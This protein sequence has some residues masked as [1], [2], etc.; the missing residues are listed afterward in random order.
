M[1]KHGLPGVA[2]AFVE[3]GEIAYTQ[4]YGK[5][6]NNQPMT[7][8][9]PMFIGSQSKSFTALAIAILADQGKL[10]LNDPVQRYIPWFQVADENASSKI[11]LNHLLHHTSGLSDSG[12]AVVLPLKTDLEDAVRSLS[13]AKLT[14]PMG[15]Q[16]QYFNMGYAVLA[17]IVEVV[18]GEAYADYVDA[19]I[20]TP[21]HMNSSSANPIEVTGIAQGYSRFFGFAIPM[22]QPVPVYAIGNGYI[23]STVEDLARYAIAM[24]SPDVNGLLSPQMRY[25]LFD[26]GIGNYAMGWFVYDNGAKIMH[27]G[28]NETFHTDVNLYPRKNRAFVLLTNQG[29][30][31]D[32]FISASQLTNSV[33]A[34][35]LGRQPASVK[36]GW[37]V[38]WFGWGIGALVFGLAALHTFNFI[39][40][41]NWKKKT[42]KFSTTR[43]ALDVAI[44]FI[45]PAVILLVI[46][47]QVAQFY[48][49]RFNLLTSLYYMRKGFPDMLVLFL[50][51]TLPDVIQGIIKIILC[52]TDKK[53]AITN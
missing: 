18:S 2:L 40:L 49:N 21:L 20:F 39:T 11:T 47:S 31:I 53:P 1:E 24:M 8:Q 16:M 36:Q 52:I 48:G 51:G 33:E 44:S 26:A 27:G 45:I 17:Y 6:G 23:V 7:P 37:S 32:H 15:Q 29:Y 30:Q 28:A 9:T 14:A 41:R 13:K 19:H 50:I 4:G 12:Y 35:V 5:A 38:K 43:K 34:V 46:L 42:Q 3:D 25:K 10:D 22:K